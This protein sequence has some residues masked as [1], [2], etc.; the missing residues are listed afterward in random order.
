MF[1]V[2]VFLANVICVL[3]MTGGV[4]LR[5]LI[6]YPLFAFVGVDQFPNYQRENRIRVQRSLQP[7][8]VIMALTTLALFFVHPSAIPLALP[9]LGV[10]LQVA[11]AAAT[12][13]EVPRQRRLEHGFDA[14]VHRQ[15]LSGNWV[16]PLGLS[17]HTAI[18]RNRWRPSSAWNKTLD[19]LAGGQGIIG[20]LRPASSPSKGRSLSSKR[21][22]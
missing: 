5:Q 18:S 19:P 8:H 9:V 20:S 1:G 10:V 14:Q 4:W 21:A 17:L 13:Y 16:R 22:L 3:F 11:V 12:A 2:A 15:L 6:Y 7:V